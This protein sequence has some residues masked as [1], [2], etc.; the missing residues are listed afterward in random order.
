MSLTYYRIDLAR[1]AR[2]MGNMVFVIGLPVL[3]YLIFGSTFTSAEET[4]VHANLQFY[5]MVSMAMYGAATAT[6]AIAGMA[7]LEL[8]QGW[9]R[10]LG[11]TPMRNSAY[12]GTKVLVA[13]TVA[14]AAVAAVFIAG[15]LTGAEAESPLIWIVTALIAW[16]GASIFALL[17]LAVAQTF[18]SESSVS[19]ASAGTVLLAFLG[20]LFVPL[21]GALLTI[22]RFTPMYGFAGLTRWPQLRGLV[23][24]NNQMTG[25][26]DPFWTLAVNYIAWF[27]IFAAVAVWA[28][29]R[30]RRRQ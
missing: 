22:A 24:E 3:M 21:T 1:Q 20:N 11:L 16:L 5:V 29:R 15:A 9:G 6:V 7:A 12:V 18:K 4:I 26:A 13:L 17:G 2:D 8:L 27:A 25:I 14:A 19:I 23:L 30:G 10:Q 28:V